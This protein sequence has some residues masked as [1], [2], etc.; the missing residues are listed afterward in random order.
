LAN[1]LSFLEGHPLLIRIV[2]KRA[3]EIGWSHTYRLYKPLEN[4]CRELGYSIECSNG[5]G[6]D[7]KLKLILEET[8]AQL[9]PNLQKRLAQLGQ[10]PLFESFEPNLGM[11]VWDIKNIQRA[12]GELNRL[13][14]MGVLQRSGKERYRMHILVRDFAHEKCGILS[15]QEQAKLRLWIWRYPLYSSWPEYRW[16]RFNVPTPPGKTWPIWDRHIPRTP[17]D[18]HR[19]QWLDH[20]INESFWMADNHSHLVITP[21]EWVIVKRKA[22]T[23]RILLCTKAILTILYL[24]RLFLKSAA[25]I[26]EMIMI[27]AILIMLL[28]LVMLW[29]WTDSRR[30]WMWHLLG[31]SLTDVLQRHQ[32]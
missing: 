20:A 28:V 3:A 19:W 17:K 32:S 16:Y 8:W 4:R 7:S 14:D 26:S 31:H 23:T 11:A 21:L 1:L 2:A 29:V 27:L 24:Y 13:V 12:E 22:L 9:S 5:Q 25:G 15:R 18:K 30:I 10:V 6:G